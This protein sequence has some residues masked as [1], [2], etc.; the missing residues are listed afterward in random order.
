MLLTIED[1]IKLLRDSVNIQNVDDEGN[2]VVDTSYLSMSDEDITRFIKLGVNR[3]YPSVSDLNDLPSDC[4]TYAICL[5]A[6]IE[7]YLTLAVLKADKV[8][9]GADNNN[10]LKNDQ[11]F[12]HYMKLANHAKEEYDSWLENEDKGEVNTYELLHTKYSHTKRYYENQQTPRVTLKSANVFAD[13]FDIGWDV[14]RITH[15]GSY[16]VYLSKSP[17]FNMFAEGSTVESHINGGATLIRQT[18]DLRNNTK[19]I[20]G[21]QPNTTYYVCVFAKCRNGVWGSSEISVTTQEEV[22]EGEEIDV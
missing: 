2:P 12:Q 5:L 21:L 16:L 6:K 18:Y 13:S 20:L 8:D 3:V 22:L 1:L 17:I 15:F 9:M 10:Y 19:H 7:L 14:D 11:R 4:S